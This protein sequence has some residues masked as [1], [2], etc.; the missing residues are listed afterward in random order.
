MNFRM[1]ENEG[2]IN[3]IKILKKK[4]IIVPP[5]EGQLTSLHTGK[6]IGKFKYYNE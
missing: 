3:A 2:T 6:K 1:W 4:A 5:E